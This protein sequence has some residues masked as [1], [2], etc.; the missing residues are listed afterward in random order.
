MSAPN[1]VLPAYAL[2]IAI[3]GHGLVAPES[4][5][6]RL[7]HTLMK[8]GVPTNSIEILA[9]PTATR[10]NIIRQLHS[11]RTHPRIVRD[12]PILI[13]FAGMFYLALVFQVL[14]LL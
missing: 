1:G 2:L 6:V 13:Y 11:I 10:N 8:L 3:N 14:P 9:G 4:D 5:A 7:Q 12:A